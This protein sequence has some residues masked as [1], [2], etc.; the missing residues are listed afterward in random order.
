MGFVSTLEKG[1]T[2]ECEITYLGWQNS[3]YITKEG[4]PFVQATSYKALE[5]SLICSQVIFY[6]LI[7]A[8]GMF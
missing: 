6:P 7:I 3:H 5:V 2:V 1:R 8:M 4:F